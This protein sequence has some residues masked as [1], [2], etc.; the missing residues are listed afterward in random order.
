MFFMQTQNFH[1]DDVLTGT[2]EDTSEKEKSETTE[3]NNVFSC[4]YTEEFVYFQRRI[5]FSWSYDGT[6]LFVF[7]KHS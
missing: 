7:I 3:W 4:I 2:S 1:K 6:F 5:L